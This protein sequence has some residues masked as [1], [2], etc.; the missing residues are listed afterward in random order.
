MK[1]KNKFKRSSSKVSGVWLLAFLFFKFYFLIGGFAQQDPQYSLYMFNHIAVNPAYAGS[2]DA[3]STA[4]V[5]RDQ[6]TNIKGAP[7]T[8][9]ISAHMPLKQNK[10]GLGAEIFTDKLGPRSTSAALFSY[11]YRIPFSTGKLAFGLRTGIFNYV[12]DWDQLE[13]KDLGDQYDILGSSSKLSGTADFGLYYYSRTFYW[14]LSSTHLNRGR[15]SEFAGDSVR[16]ARHYFITAGKSFK[17]GNTVI[18]PTL[19]LKSAKNAPASCDLGVNVLLKEKWWVGLSLRSSYGIIILSQLQISE[20]FRLGYAYDLGRNGIG[21]A[22]GGSHEIML[23]YDINIMGA[24]V[25]M[26]RYL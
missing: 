19:M 16:Q 1:M 11:A 22:G 12:Y 18:N 23:G 17:V 8:A 14:G 6:W 7:T 13:F 21:K 15:M 20:N 24:K 3:F 4:F 10:L 26:P 9:A 5:Y 25:T 2:R